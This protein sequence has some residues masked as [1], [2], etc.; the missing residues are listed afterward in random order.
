[1][2]LNLTCPQCGKR[3]TMDFSTS[4]V[5]CQHCGYVRPDEIAHLEDVTRHAKAQGEHPAVEITYHG[6]IMP[7]ALAAFETGQDWLFKGDK[8]E[9]LAAFLRS[10]DYQ[11][12]FVDAHLWIA[13]VC[14][15]PAV[16][17]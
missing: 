7:S 3:M 14:D 11:P 15:D 8:H 5:S 10:A 6:E 16:K 2:G 1:M 9:A 4:T 17:R 13:K 12:D